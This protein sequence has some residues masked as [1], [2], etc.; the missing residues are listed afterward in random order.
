MF[1]KILMFAILF[2]ICLTNMINIKAEE[3]FT[4]RL[5]Y[6]EVEGGYI[7]VDDAKCKDTKIV[8]PSTYQ[9]KPVIGIKDHAFAGNINL[10]SISIPNSITSI[11]EYAFYDC[12]S[13][14]EVIFEDDSQL[15]SIGKR[16][17]SYTALESIIIPKS[18]KTL[19]SYAFGVC[20][21]LKVIIF[22]DDS[23]LTSIG[24]Y[25][26][27]ECMKL[28]KVIFGKN[29]QLISMDN[30]LFMNCEKLESIEIPSSVT[31]IGSS[32]FYNCPNLE[33]VIFEDD[34]Q[35]TSIGNY[36]FYN[37]TNLKKVIFGKNSQLTNMGN[38]LFMNCENLESI[39]IPNSVTSLDNSTF[40]NCRSLK[41]L[42]IPKSV[43]S[44]S[45][46]VFISCI[47]LKN[48]YYEGTIED[49]C[50]IT[51]AQYDSNPM[52]YVENIYMLDSNDECY[53]VKEIVIPNTITSI[54]NYQFYGFDNLEKVTIPESVTSIGNYAF[55]DCKSLANITI[56][57][58][59]TSIGNYAFSSCNIQVI[60]NNSDLVFEIGS[61]NY[62]NIAKNALVIIDKNGVA[63]CKD[64]YIIKD[65]F[66][67][68]NENDQYK[69]ISYIGT[70]D[71][72]TLPLDINGEEYTIYRMTGVKNLIIPKEFTEIN[73]YAF[74]DCPSLTSI[75]IPNN[76]TSLERY[77][78]YNC[79][80]L[81]E[82]YYD[83][84]IENWC[85]IQFKNSSSN[86]MNCAKHFYMKDSNNEYYEVTE[87]V[88]PDTVSRIGD[89][90]F[91]GFD[92][93]TKIELSDSVKEI[94][95]SAF[96]YC[97]SL[98]SIEIPNSVEKVQSEAFLRC[99]QLVIY[100]EK[101]VN[102]ENWS[103][104]WNIDN[105]QVLIVSDKDFAESSGCKKDL[106]FLV[107]GLI[108]LSML[109]ALMNKKR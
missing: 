79:P 58:S 64:G 4:Q 101:D 89:F 14:K 97:K 30:N 85:N 107:I 24:N 43:V 103:E 71:T 53:K 68:I 1:K 82:V 106:S 57:E 33:E 10:E 86:P 26:F 74:Y 62:G 73:S 32:A 45:D 12:Y 23:Q 105:N 2:T 5:K 95:A 77:A 66:L 94:G 100:L 108:S 27:F 49:W 41:S 29:S 91:Y 16:A 81:E 42:T 37:C 80:S 11:G 76:V 50:N 21:N 69:L 46:S 7:V 17:F 52:Y 83:G 48:V 15:T 3:T 54:S 70:E 99:Y 63:T 67:F 102:T 31:T 87:L 104:I 109:V 9:G 38:N 59:V 93:L 47:N 34:S 25:A 61:S 96:A 84:T 75:E 90:N 65:D 8:I 28:N 19:G 44:I 55:S 35:L 6:E 13:L 92:N 20:F 72:V 40:Y 18:V 36:A 56:P 60:I 88:I 22:E 39:E 78:F 51:F 98:K